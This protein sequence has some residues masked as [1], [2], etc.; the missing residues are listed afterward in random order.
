MATQAAWLY[1]ALA[2]WLHGFTVLYTG[3]IGTVHWL[4]G[5]MGAVHCL[6]VYMALQG[7]CSGI[8]A[9]NWHCTGWA[10]LVIEMVPPWSGKHLL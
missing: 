5:Y 10:Y 3:N 7:N 2:T 6:H 4:H 1:S 9:L 8:T